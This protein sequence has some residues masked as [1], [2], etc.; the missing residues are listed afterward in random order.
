MKGKSKFS[1]LRMSQHTAPLDLAASGNLFRKSIWASDPT[2]ETVYGTGQ[3][4]CT[5]SLTDR[6][7]ARSLVTSRRLLC[8]RFRNGSFAILLRGERTVGKRPSSCHEGSGSFLLSPPESRQSRNHPN[9]AV[10]PC[11]SRS[12]LPWGSASPEE[13]QCGSLRP[14]RSPACAPPHRRRCV[15][16]RTV[17]RGQGSGRQRRGC[18]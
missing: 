12:P 18:R 17:R 13:S 6:F 5:A 7:Q 16:A 10:A 8:C 4:R 3:N 9:L 1:A 14:P 11:L 15:R 2:H